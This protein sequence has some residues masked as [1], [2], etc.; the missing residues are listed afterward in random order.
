MVWSGTSVR[1]FQK[2]YISNRIIGLSS[3]TLS[4]QALRV[5]YACVLLG[6]PLS[7]LYFRNQSIEELLLTVHNIKLAGCNDNA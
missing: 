3:T 7:T 1:V 2:I 5:G 6:S 4:A